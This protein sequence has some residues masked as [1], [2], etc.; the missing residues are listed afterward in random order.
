MNKLFIDLEDS[1]DS[2]L[3]MCICATCIQMHNAVYLLRMQKF[4]KKN[5]LT[6][7]I[8]PWSINNPR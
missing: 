8:V 1:I 7:F 6:F 4:I 5:P 3:Q 2:V